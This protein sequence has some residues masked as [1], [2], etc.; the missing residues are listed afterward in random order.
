[1]KKKI[2]IGFGA[3]LGGL[4][5]VATT[6]SASA[7]VTLKKSYTLND[8]ALIG[9][10]QGI[11]FK[12]GGFSSL[13]PIQGTNGKEFWAISDRGVNVDAANANDAACRPTYDKIYAFPSYVPKIHRV[14][15]E[16]N[17]IKVL[18]TITM[19]R[20]DGTGASGLINPTGFGS[21]ATEQ[22][23]IDTVLNCAN[24]AA[25]IVAKDVWGIDAEGL[26]VDK[27]GN[28]WIAEEGGPTVWKLNKN[29]VVVK[30][31][32][33][34]AKQA[35]A[36]SIDVAI[37]T[38]FKYRK[39]NRG[40]EGLALTPNGKLYAFIQSP[41]LYPTK[42]IGEA[43]RVHRI[44]EIDPATDQTK[45]FAYLNEG[46]VGTGSNQ[47]R[48]RDWKI[49][50]FAAINDSTFLVIEA[51]L[52]GTTDVKKVYKINITGATAV[53]SG[54]Y[55]GKTLEGLVDLAGLT[56]NGIQPVK[57][58][59]FMDLLALGW[60]AALEK[61]EGLAIVNDSTIVI[62]NDNDYGQ[63]S[64]TENGVA[65]AT[66]FQTQLFVFGLS[67]SNKLKHLVQ[68]QLS[69]LSG[70][71]GP[72]TL[73]SPYLQATS[74]KDWYKSILTVGDKVSGYKMAG[75]PDGMGAFDTGDGNF[76][77]VLNHEMGNTVGSV[78]AHG[79][80]G[81]FVSKWVIRKSDLTVLSGADLIQTVNL[82]NG[83]G[84]TAYN[85]SNT[86]S[87]AAMG[88]FCSADLPEV[89]AFY[90]ELTGKG[91]KERIFMN[92]E[93]TGSEGRGF[94]HVIT[95]TE[96]GMTYELPRLG[97]FSWENSVASPAGGDK[98]TVVGLDDATPGQIYVYVGTKQTSGNTIEKA[99]L[100]NGKLFGVAVKDL[101]AETSASIPTANTVFTLVDL[102]NVANKTG[103]ELNTMSNNGGVTNFLRPEDGAWDPSNP[104]DFYFVTTNS[105]TNPSRLWRL[106]FTD[107]N[108]PELGGSIT[109]VLDGTEGQKMLDNLTVDNAGHV[110]LVEDVGGNAHIGKVWDYNTKTDVL[111]LVGSHDETRFLNGASQ[112]LTQDEEAS[113]IIDV[114]PIL[115][116]GM[117]LLVDQAHYSTGDAETVEGGQLLAFYHQ[118]TADSAAQILS[119]PMAFT[120]CQ[121]GT[122]EF[123]VSAK[124]ASFY[125]WQVK[126]GEVFENLKN[127]TLYADVNKAKL[128]VKKAI[129]GLNNMEYRCLVGRSTGIRE[130][131]ALAKLMVKPAATSLTTVT[132]CGAKGAYV[133]NGKS[134][135]A[136]G[137]YTA[138]LV[139]KNGCDS[140]ATLNLSFE[141]INTEIAF[142]NGQLTAK[143]QV[144]SFQWFNC[145]TKKNVAG[146]TGKSFRPADSGTYSVIVTKGSCKDTSDCMAVSFVGINEKA[147]ISGINVYPN[148]ASTLVKVAIDA[149]TE[150]SATIQLVDAAGRSI[151]EEQEVNL[152]LGST[153]VEI[154]VEK[155]TNGM[156][157]VQVK[158]E[159]TIQLIRLTIAK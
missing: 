7:Q 100:N 132:T 151:T 150:G 10:F 72:S 65:T 38:C 128:V 118:A 135:N 125:Q 75:L 34:Y 108:N 106:R 114:Q 26:A 43:T 22:A 90:N 143:E 102:G 53:N 13:Y 123:S 94:A 142:E 28:F 95:G 152:T 93:E 154:P 69:N 15:I 107:I 18:Q 23:S 70:I 89:S 19:K 126:K 32:T 57:K 76:A 14:R 59:L 8:P 44:L 83:T 124:N 49:G 74:S 62:G 66:N 155:L 12:E 159:N 31:Y 115:G 87:A 17:S 134:Y 120:T 79:Q 88:R 144:G 137:V 35:G 149:T 20:P 45:M 80:K 85:S 129:N 21:T 60:P 136:S 78:H 127:D 86:V 96:A 121:N 117:F 110:L 3:L 103:A 39:N 91:T 113:G 98:T 147:G 133:W 105:F 99:G 109:A 112:F 2:T 46:P 77:V 104:N 138:K 71:T 84:F 131:S 61:A 157:F 64:P 139:A 97:K 48:F 25:K 146:A 82:W 24:F 41:I 1:M 58:E 158:K 37:D 130:E 56:A 145:T 148:P 67:G 68:T 42:A 122:A 30:R 27:A 63:F 47:I 116:K 81:A 111:T 52:R 156:Y 33:P 140:I 92:G 5:C 54:L 6:G 50:D 119:Q 51:G 36:E 55:G 16:G 40:F 101:A 11:D 9:T 73:Q 4:L 153:I 141:T 29:G